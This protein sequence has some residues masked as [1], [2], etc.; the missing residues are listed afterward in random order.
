V[1]LRGVVGNH[2]LRL[3][4]VFCA[5]KTGDLVRAVLLSMSFKLCGLAIATVALL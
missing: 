5:L 4:I 2:F 1:N 3:S